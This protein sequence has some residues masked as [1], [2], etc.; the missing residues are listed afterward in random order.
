[1]V[2]DF[3][4]MPE[5][6]PPQ[7]YE[8]ILEGDDNVAAR[9][10]A[11]AAK[12]STPYVALSSI[13]VC[14][15]YY[16]IDAGHRLFRLVPQKKL[17]ISVKPIQVGMWVYGDNSG[18]IVRCRFSDSTGQVFQ[19]EG[20]PIDWQGWRYKTMPFDGTDSSWWGGAADGRLHPPLHWDT[21]FLFDTAGKE[22]KG[23]AYLGPVMLISE[24]N[25]MEA[26]K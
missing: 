9:V 8:I 14:K 11:E 20:F 16:D 1:M 10:I 19:P 12:R 26:S 15:M 3:S 21:L 18:A 4:Y 2:E 13:P 6:A 17:P 24:Y 7:D 23:V 25:D 22:M 5:D